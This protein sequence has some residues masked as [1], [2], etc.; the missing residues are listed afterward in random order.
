MLFFTTGNDKEKNYT[1]SAEQAFNTYSNMV[2]RLA[3]T[4]TGSKSMADD[5]LQDVFVAYLRKN[6]KFY[7]KE[8]LKAWLLRVTLNC[9]NNSLKSTWHSRSVELDVQYVASIE[10]TSEVYFEVLKLPTKY[11]TVIHL[12][13]YE[14]YSVKEIASIC[15]TKESTIKTRLFRAREQLKQTLKGEEFDV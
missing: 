8:H 1:L 9:S 15:K 2:W 10:N 11:R 5:I 7:D 3:L 14:G 13:Y 12:H 6:P 4:K